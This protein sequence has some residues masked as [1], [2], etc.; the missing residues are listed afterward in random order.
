[1]IGCHVRGARNVMIF[2]IFEVI[3]AMHFYF[4]CTCTL[5]TAC[6]TSNIDNTIRFNKSRN[7]DGLIGAGYVWCRGGH[8]RIFLETSPGNAD[9][10]SMWV[11]CRNRKL[12]HQAAIQKMGKRNAEKKTHTG[13]CDPESSEK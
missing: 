2:N 10:M 7:A 1:M 3:R 13:V 12:R 11:G 9:E 4:I 5:A 6:P 8:L